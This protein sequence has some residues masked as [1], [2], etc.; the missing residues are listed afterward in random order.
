MLAA[1]DV[2]PELADTP[3]HTTRPHRL[4]GQTVPA[5]CPLD[6]ARPWSCE[7]PTPRGSLHGRDGAKH[8]ARPHSENPLSA[9]DAC[10]LTK[11]LALP[12]KAQH[13]ASGFGFHGPGRRVPGRPHWG[14]T[15]FPEGEHGTR[16]E[17]GKKK[18]QAVRETREGRR[19]QRPNGGIG[20]WITRGVACGA[21]GQEHVKRRRSPKVASPTGSGP[22][23]RVCS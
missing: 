8:G 12:G 23:A 1:G 19:G 2:L 6:P 14:A 3:P 7:K 16:E 9:A 13:E 17:R 21:Y 5:C 15:L 11:E 4:S 10:H 18:T 20:I 22:P